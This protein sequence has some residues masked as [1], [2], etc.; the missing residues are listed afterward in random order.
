MDEQAKIE[1]ARAAGYTDDE[2]NQYL[3]T[4]DQPVPQQQPINRS[5][6]YKGLG[7]SSGFKFNLIISVRFTFDVAPKILSVLGGLGIIL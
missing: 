1:E 3:A 7:I 6:E 2:I 5:E 4:K